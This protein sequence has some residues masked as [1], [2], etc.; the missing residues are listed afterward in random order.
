M[1]VWNSDRTVITKKGMQL[2]SDIAGKKALVLSKAVAGSDYTDPALLESMTDITHQQMDM[3]FSEFSRDENGTAYVDVYIENSSV[4]EGFYHQQIGIFAKDTDDNDVLFLVAQA[5]SPD[6]IPTSATP[7]YITHRIFMQFS[8]NSDVEVKVDFSGVVTQ[9]VLREELKK[10]EN[11]FEKNSAFNKNF[12]DSAGDYATLGKKAYAG[13]SVSVA[14]ADHV[15]PVGTILKFAENNW[16]S[17]GKTNLLPDTN[18][19][20]MSNGQTPAVWG[21]Y[22]F[23]ATFTGAWEGFS[24][25]FDE[26]RLAKVQG[27]KVEFGVDYL[28][29]ASSRLELIVDGNAVNYIL[30]TETA[31]S[32]SVQIPEG[33]SSVTLRVIIFSADDL[34]CAFGGVY[35]YDAQEEAEKPDDGDALF[36]SVRKVLQSALPSSAAS[37]TVYLTE[38]GNLYLG[39]DDGSLLPLAGS[40]ELT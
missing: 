4:T 13:G 40:D 33:T 2:L 34:H 37:G 10:K 6:Y 38:K 7:V 12:S 35:L 21:G 27:K 31:A 18:R 32:V 39:K 19:W 8:G 23:E 36:L 15:H 3:K 25:F 14:R 22:E 24:C 30:Q 9:D 20:V 17:G 28:T 11:A 26:D 29:G 16:D 1:G 5:D